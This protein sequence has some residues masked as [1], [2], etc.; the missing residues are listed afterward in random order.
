MG[1]IDIGCTGTFVRGRTILTA[2]LGHSFM[3]RQS[4]QLV[5]VY[6]EVTTVQVVGTSTYNFV[7]QRI[8]TQTIDITTT[9][10]ELSLIIDGNSCH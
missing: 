1:R 5:T 10:T 8:A 2:A 6:I 7:V 9:A 4:S 3:A